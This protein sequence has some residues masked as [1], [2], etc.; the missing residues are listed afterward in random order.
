MSSKTHCLPKPLTAADISEVIQLAWED[1]TT[2]ETIEE[3]LGLSEADVI[4]IMRSSLKP[5][6]FS[7]WRKR[8]RGR[9][10]KHRALRDPRMKFSD[11]HTADHRRAN[12]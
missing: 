9:V 10:T 5:S 4:S 7:L 2:F 8:M 6:S 3:R 12:C 11:R 1:R